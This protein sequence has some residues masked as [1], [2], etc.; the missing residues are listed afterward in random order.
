MS[1]KA[2]NIFVVYALGA[3]VTLTVMGLAGVTITQ[4]HVGCITIMLFWP[5]FVLKYL[6]IGIQMVIYT[7][8]T[9]LF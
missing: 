2:F 8:L 5:L 1:D 6:I 4:S 9:A 3:V 7:L